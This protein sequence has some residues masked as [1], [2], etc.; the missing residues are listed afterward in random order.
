MKKASGGE[1]KRV[2]TSEL[3][4]R[5][6]RPIRRRRFLRGSAALGAAVGVTT[7]AGCSPSGTVSAP[8]PPSVAVAT[9]PATAA[10][11]LAAPS[12]TA[13]AFKL[14]GTFR[15]AYQNEAPN[16]DPHMV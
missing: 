11:S 13:P 9:V 3:A 7:L 4:C 5:W 14:G 8:T 1:E 6:R 15:G 2:D 16:L 12:A 10:P